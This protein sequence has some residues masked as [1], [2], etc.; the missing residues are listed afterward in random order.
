MNS[1]AAFVFATR[2]TVEE[3]VTGVIDTLADEL[4]TDKSA[5]ADGRAVALVTEDPEMGS[6]R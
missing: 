5:A 1:G 6:P 2:V 4:P 3:F